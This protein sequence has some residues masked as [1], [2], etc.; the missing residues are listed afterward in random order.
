MASLLEQAQAAVKAREYERALELYNQ[1]VDADLTAD[2]LTGRA[3]VHN[4]LNNHMEAAA[5]ASRAVE[6]DASLAMAHRERGLACYHL[7]E[8]ESALD[9]FQ[10]ACNLEPSKNIHRQWLNMCRVQLGED[11]EQPVRKYDAPPAAPEPAAANEGP[12]TSSG[13]TG[14]GGINLQ[15]EQLQAFLRAAQAGQLPA[16]LGGAAG[17]GGR[18]AP[19][20]EEIEEGSEKPLHVTVDDPEFSKYWKAPIAASVAA[21]IPDKPAGAKY[22]HQWFQSP[23]RVEVNILAKGLKKE[24]V[25]VTIEEQRLRVATMSAEGQEDFS[26]DLQLHAPIVPGESCFEV[27]GTKVEIKLKKAQT[28]R[29]W[30]GLEAG[31]AAAAAAPTTP[32]APEPQAGAVPA[33]AEQPAAAPPAGPTAVYPYA[34]KKVDWDKLADE[35]KKEEKEEKLDGDAGLWKFFRELYD[36]GDEDTRRAMVK[37]MQESGGTALS[38]NWDD[39]G[40]KDYSKKGKEGQE[41]DDDEEWAHR[42]SSRPSRR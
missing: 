15:G 41:E 42:S 19:V 10:E 9:A 36:G 31:G 18:P 33:A 11:P 24:Q 1:A 13:S 37:S 25:G 4:K 2:A 14:G 5:D 32:A 17:P 38:M 29:Q 7:E 22:R 26:L 20:I 40:K 35:I 30:P 12:S 21:S 28:G 34:G 3:A 23:D 6:L 16:A 8:Y 39:V 27:L